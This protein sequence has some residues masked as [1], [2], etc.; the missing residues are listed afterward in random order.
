MGPLA[1]PV[2]IQVGPS[3][4]PVAT[5]AG[6]ERLAEDGHDMPLHGLPLLRL[7]ICH[8]PDELAAVAGA[9]QQFKSFFVLIQLGFVDINVCVMLAG[10]SL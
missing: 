2:P 10:L 5:A 8:L 4:E 7:V 3:T 1:R 6:V 9:L